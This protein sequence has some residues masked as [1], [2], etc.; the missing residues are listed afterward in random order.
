[1]NTKKIAIYAMLTALTVGVSLVI[2]IPIPGTNGFVTLCEVGIYTA[3]ALFGPMGGLIVG[4]GSGLFID[5]LS[6]YP[7]WAIFSLLIHGLQGLV[8]GYFFASW[9]LYDWPVG[10]ASLP[11]NLV[12]NIVGIVVAIPLTK[13]LM[14]LP[15]QQSTVKNK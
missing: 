5:L 6:G 15:L 12:Q 14:R 8:A 3:A 11:S 2:L 7:Q 1:M 10:V 9:L 13:A 4:A